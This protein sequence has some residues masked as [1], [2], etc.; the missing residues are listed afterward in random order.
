MSSGQRLSSSGESSAALPAEELRARRLAALSGIGR[1][2][3]NEPITP[4][5]RNGDQISPEELP[6]SFLNDFSSLMF[7]PVTTSDAD[8]RRWFTQPIHTRF[9]NSCEEMGKEPEKHHLWGLIQTQ[10]GPC[11][12]IAALQAEMIQGLKIYEDIERAITAEEAKR[13]L[14]QAIATIIARCAVAPPVDSNNSNASTESISLEI[15]LPID[16]EISMD[17][18]N[19]S[20]GKLK[21]ISIHSNI[22]KRPRSTSSSAATNLARATEDFLM[23]NSNMKHFGRPCGVILFLLS[24][25]K[26]RGVA[27]IKS[28]KNHKKR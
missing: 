10:G 23:E 15:V 2:P 13:V 17:D 26:T 18:L 7:D 5:V 21:V 8:K 9:G 4:Q 19:L 11:G 12:V 25:V 20:S 24:L 16:D 6:A 22:V 28:G 14:C 1:T 3:I 27:N